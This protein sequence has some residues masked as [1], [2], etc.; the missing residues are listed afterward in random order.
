MRNLRDAES[1]QQQGMGDSVPP[2]NPS[3]PLLYR[4]TYG[5]ADSTAGGGCYRAFD[6]RMRV[7][8]QTA[9]VG[10][11]AADPS[12]HSPKLRR[13]KEGKR[14]GERVEGRALVPSSLTHERTLETEGGDGTGREG[15]R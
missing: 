7:A 8:A 1:R 3:V 4:R 12:R 10:V 2:G 6:G 15:M 11:K 5:R 13:K 14:T 9:S